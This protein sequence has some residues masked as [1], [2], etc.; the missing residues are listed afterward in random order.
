MLLDFSRLGPWRLVLVLIAL[1]VGAYLLLPILLI[2][3]LSFGS[4]RWLQFP[5]PGWT[6]RW[7]RELFDDP[8]WIASFLTSFR[9]AAVVTVLSVVIG[10][11]ASFGLTRGEFRGR[12]LLRALFLTPM[13]LPVV[14]L[15]VALYAFFLRLHLNGTFTGFV[16]AHLVVALPFSIIAISNALE[17]FDRDIETAAIVCGASPLEAKLRVT[18]PGIRL[19]LMSAALFSFLASW[20]EVVIAIF[21]ASPD[22]QTLPVRIFSTLRQD[23]SPV[24]AAVSTVLIALTAGLM[25]LAALLRKDAR[26]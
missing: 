24:I 9:I 18:L 4:S 15:A 5:P 8:A 25:A 20:D 3:G 12:E 21:M 26:S 7:Y 10:L 22:L 19:G 6:L 23:L 11:M 1:L 2:V 16:L 14:V 13:I 17:R